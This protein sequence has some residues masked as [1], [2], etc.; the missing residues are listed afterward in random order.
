[1]SWQELGKCHNDRAPA[2]WCHRAKCQLHA[3]TPWWYQRSAS[4]ASY[5]FTCAAL[6]LQSVKLSSAGGKLGTLLRLRLWMVTAYWYPLAAL[7]CSQ[8]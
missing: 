8:G 7:A 3:S 4:T 1:M 6:R 2:T 5:A